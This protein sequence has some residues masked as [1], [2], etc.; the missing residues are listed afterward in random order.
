[1]KMLADIV[2]DTNVLVHAHNTKQIRF[3][4]SQDLLIELRNC[5]TNLCVDEGF[6]LDEAQNKSQI[7]SEYLK[8]LRFGMLGLAVIAHLASS[9]RIRQLSRQVP[10]NVGRYIRQQGVPKPDRIFLFVAYNSQSKTVTCH[11]FNDLPDTVR[12]RLR[13]KIGLQVLD[14]EEALAAMR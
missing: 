6:H 3:Q 8:H 13:K 12:A 2:L 4:A 10:P 7:G 14:A 11:D 5:N 9:L 1:M